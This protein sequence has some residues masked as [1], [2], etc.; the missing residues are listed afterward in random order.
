MEANF[1]QNGCQYRALSLLL[2]LKTTTE[3]SSSRDFS[4]SFFIKPP[5]SAK[6]RESV[7]SAVTLICPKATRPDSW[8]LKWYAIS[9]LLF[10]TVKKFCIPTASQKQANQIQNTSIF[11]AQSPYNVC[12]TFP[13]TICHLLN[14]CTSSGCAIPHCGVSRKPC[15]LLKQY[16]GRISG[17]YEADKTCGIKLSSTRG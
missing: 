12:Y 2:T 4:K 8:V 11:M 9:K 5:A 1:L 6:E 15:V 17:R 7:F 16:T 10:F 13:K 14:C 3:T